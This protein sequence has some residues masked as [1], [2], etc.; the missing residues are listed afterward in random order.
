MRIAIEQHFA[1]FQHWRVQ[2]A[3]TLGDYRDWMNSTKDADLLQDLRLYDL[4]EALKKDRLVLAFVAE[5][6]RGKT[7]TINALFFADYDQR[8]LPSES[9]RTTMCPAELFWNELDEPCIRLLP[10]ETRKRDDSVTYLKSNPNE[11]VKLR[12]DINSPA[13]MKES[14]RALAQQKEVTLE[15]A[16]ALGLWDDADPAMMQT[17]QATGKVNIP[18]W[19]HALV[20]FPHPLLKNGL[21]ILDTPGLNALGTE[22]E[23][24]LK[25]IPNAHA[26]FFL[27]ATDTGVTKSDLQIWKQCIH[28]RGNCKVAV[29]NKIDMLWDAMKSEAEINA[30]IQLQVE[31][32]ARQLNLPASSVI[33]ISAKK[34]LVAKIK[35]DPVLLERSGISK[36]EQFIAE[37]VIGA[38]HEILRNSIVSE[39]SA[40]VKDSRKKIQQR[41]AMAQEQLVEL[42]TVQH[43]GR[44]TIQSML[45]NVT[46]EKK[47]LEASANAFA[48]SNMLISKLGTQLLD[49]LDDHYVSTLMEENRQQID[50]SWTTAGLNNGIKKFTL[51][52]SELAEKLTEFS[53]DIQAVALEI[54]VRFHREHGY[55]ARAPQALEMDSFVNNMLALEKLGDEFCADPVNV[56]TEK[57]FLVRKFFLGLGQQIKETFSQAHQEAQRWIQNILEPLRLQ[58]EDHQTALD[59]RMESLMQ[60]HQNSN[61]VQKNIQKTEQELLSLKKQAATL[62]ILLL[63]LVKTAKPHL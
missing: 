47:L 2:L 22:P 37:K 59:G 17:L 46:A 20:N 25:V 14:L 32:T 36:I 7:E 8:L 4:E 15:E 55:E 57:H 16:R 49:Q 19:R 54:Y 26:V 61:S 34:A 45:A 31:T 27:L 41:I 28:N 5:F 51:Q 12:L 52:T 13:S 11:W 21:V 53:Q 39:T 6:S 38:K 63:N 23:L 60:A 29:L 50:N 35:K 9:G 40:M 10:I 48:Q 56:M 1:E 42:Q 3:Q 33:A 24:T 44:N 30:I 62:D 58:I 43:K 18:V